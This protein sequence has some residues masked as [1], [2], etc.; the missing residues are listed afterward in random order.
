LSATTQGTAVGSLVIEEKL[1]RTG[2]GDVLLARQPG[3]ARRVLVR[4]LRRDLLANSTLVE[5]FRREARMAARVCHPGVQQVFDLFAWHGDH[6]LVL[7]HV[8]G[9]SLCAWIE[10]L[11]TPP[12]RVGRAL[13]LELAR[14]VEALHAAGVVHADLCAD[15]VRVGRWGEVKLG[16]LAWARAANESGVPAPDPTPSSAPEVADGS[17][18]DVRSDVFSLGLLIALL[19]TGKA[20]APRG[21]GAVGRL[22]RRA[23]HSD[24]A[25]RPDAA[26]LRARL[27]QQLGGVSVAEIRA[28]IAGWL[29]PRSEAVASPVAATA[30]RKRRLTPARVAALSG[31]AAGLAAALF[32]GWERRALAPG[33]DAPP[34]VRVAA[35]SAPSEPPSVD[36][37]TA[38]TPLPER[39]RLRVAVFPWGEV[40]IDG[41][42]AIVTP[43]AAP[44]DLAPGPHRIEIVHPTLGREVREI[45]LAAGERRTLHHVFDRTP[46]E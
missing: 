41:G 37:G 34:S 25:R 45:T 24:P 11:G 7:E 6:Y 42:D 29:L 22:L 30:P 13:A 1:A 38:P 10:R 21:A 3:L 44:V 19:V 27:E 4:T 23:I 28:E 39:A 32:V 2:S 8:E 20:A 40:R 14:A 16:G 9:D 35:S 33:K 46:L 12:A 31:A 15:N 26:S 43:R 36:A 17:A 5:R 18:P